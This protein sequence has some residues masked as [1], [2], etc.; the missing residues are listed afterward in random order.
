MRIQS[1][2]FKETF[3]RNIEI[4]T[5]LEAKN[6]TILGEEA[7]VQQIVL[8][9]AVN[10]RDAMPSGGKLIFKTEN[11]FG[12]GFEADPNV[13]YIVMHV[14]DTGIGVSDEV[15]KRIFEPFFTTKPD[16][17]RMSGK[18]TLAHLLLINPNVKVIVATGYITESEKEEVEGVAGF[19]EK[20]FDIK[21]L[22][23][24]IAKILG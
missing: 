11:R 12:N 1:K 15:K 4:E 22:L 19:I 13:E 14:I 3:P 18:D 20:P 23:E 2:V 5:Y 9:L 17:P 10:S 7:Q 24:M 8:N 21:K 6:H 16:M